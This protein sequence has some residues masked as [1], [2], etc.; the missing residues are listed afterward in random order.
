MLDV[1]DRGVA[2]TLHQSAVDGEE[3]TARGMEDEV[4]RAGDGEPTSTTPRFLGVLN[5]AIVLDE[6]SSMESSSR[7][8]MGMCMGVLGRQLTLALKMRT[9]ETVEIV[10]LRD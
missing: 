7:C 4:S 3:L 2:F 8:D 1:V 6:S 9:I 10:G 5:C